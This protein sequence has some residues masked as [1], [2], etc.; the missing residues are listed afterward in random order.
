MKTFVA[1]LLLPGILLICVIGGAAA[2]CRFKRLDVWCERQLTD[3][4]SNEATCEPH[5]PKKHRKS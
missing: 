3:T 1:L 5:L 2:L 4:D